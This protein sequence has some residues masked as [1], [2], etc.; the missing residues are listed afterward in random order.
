MLLVCIRRGGTAG[1]GA[2]VVFRFGE[3]G[4]LAIG[5][6]YGGLLLAIFLW[7]HR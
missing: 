6:L 5:F 7:R 4:E 3:E 1:S 2:L